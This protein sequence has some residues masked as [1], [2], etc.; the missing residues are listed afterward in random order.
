MQPKSTKL[1]ET[2]IFFPKIKKTIEIPRCSTR[3]I[4][5]F[6]IVAVIMY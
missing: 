5:F 4:N 6:S 1:D 2:V 3:L